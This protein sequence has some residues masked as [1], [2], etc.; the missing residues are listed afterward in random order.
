LEKSR[1]T[2]SG[3]FAIELAAE[4]HRKFPPGAPIEGASARTFARIV[5]ELCARARAF[6]RENRLGFYG[7]ARFGTEFKY[8]LEDLGYP[9]A[10][11]DELTRTLLIRMS[12]E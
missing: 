6:Q 7:K 11:A 8:R 5:D 3:D 9:E 1:T 10:L 4:L 2:R 12:A